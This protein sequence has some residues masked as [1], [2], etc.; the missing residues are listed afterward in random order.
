MATHDV[1][2]GDSRSNAKP[3]IHDALLQRTSDGTTSW[4]QQVNATSE[5]RIAVDR[6]R[7]VGYDETGTARIFFGIVP[8]LGNEPVLAVSLEG[9]DVLTALGTT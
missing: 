4:S 3:S 5:P 8:E 7:M 1:G 6:A 2:T 9:V